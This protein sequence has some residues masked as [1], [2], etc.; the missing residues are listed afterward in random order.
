MDNPDVNGWRKDT[1]T[2]AEE[3][4]PA[5]FFVTTGGHGGWLIY[6]EGMMNPIESHRLKTEALES[7][8]ALARHEAPSQ[9]LVEQRDGSFK[10]CFACEGASFVA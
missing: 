4:A 2:T 1:G 8:K 7:A 9:V 3:T 10:A 6:R 5:R